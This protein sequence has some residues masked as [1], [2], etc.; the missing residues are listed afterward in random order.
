MVSVVGCDTQVTIDARA[1]EE[2]R[3]F[4]LRA[5]T[6]MQVKVLARGT[7]YV[8][9]QPGCRLAEVRLA[10]R[11]PSLAIGPIRILAGPQWSSELDLTS[12]EFGVGPLADRMGLRLGPDVR[13]HQIS[14]ASEPTTVG[15]VQW[16]PSGELIVLGPDG[17]TLGGYPKPAVLARADLTRLGQLGLR[18]FEFEWINRDQ[19]AEMRQQAEAN[20]AALLRAISYRVR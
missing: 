8:A 12:R 13:P 9:I 3:S 6:T 16:T 17:P 10:E 2:N 18:P 11:S 7:A 15:A 5:G 19:A 4:W 14:I 1:L 20:L